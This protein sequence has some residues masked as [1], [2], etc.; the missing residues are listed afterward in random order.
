LGLLSSILDAVTGKSVSSVV[1]VSVAMQE[2]LELRGQFDPNRLPAD[3]STCSASWTDIA[4]PLRMIATARKLVVVYACLSYL[5]DAV[6]ESPIRVYR[7][8]KDDRK[9]VPDHR[10][11]RVLATP[12]P[13][14]S[15][16]EFLALNVM[17]MGMHAVI[18]MV[19][20]GGGL[21]VQLWPLRPDWLTKRITANGRKTR[22]WDDRVPGED[23][24][25]ILD[26]DLIL[27]PYRHDE[28]QEQPAVT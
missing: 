21:P 23:L 6:A 12:N 4:D 2:V 26:E 10:C 1:P 28:R 8:I 20:S 16:A 9:D 22:V 11:R 3:L 13:H 27:I 25:V 17:A 5:A 7:T 19:R 18:E 15:E 24:R 14:M